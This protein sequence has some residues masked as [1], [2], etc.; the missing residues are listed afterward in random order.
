MIMDIS[1]DGISF[2]QDDV[3]TDVGDKL[4]GLQRGLNRT[5]D[6]GKTLTNGKLKDAINNVIPNPDV[7]DLSALNDKLNQ[8]KDGFNS[9]KNKAGDQEI[10]GEDV[11]T[12]MECLGGAGEDIANLFDNFNPLNMLDGKIDLS[13]VGKV[14]EGAASWALDNITKGINFLLDP[15]EKL[16][17]DAISSLSGLLDIGALDKLLQLL[18]CVENCPGAEG[19]NSSSEPLNQYEVFCKNEQKKYTVFSAKEPM[20]DGCP[21]DP[22]HFIQLSDTKLIRKNVPS[23]VVVEDQLSKV[24]LTLNGEVDWDSDALKDLPISSETKDKM[25]QISEFKKGAADKLGEAKKFSPV[26]DPPE[27]PSIPKVENPLN[28]MSV[29]KK[30]ES[31]F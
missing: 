22:N 7:I 19:F 27:I 15:T 24:G 4:G 12:L 17:S 9:F 31:L 3:C 16:L 6:K 28:K 10:G 2:S 30:I 26:P 11:K 13:A 21:K 20:V 14:L 25:N 5:L 18:Q 1:P 29:A 23:S 8:A